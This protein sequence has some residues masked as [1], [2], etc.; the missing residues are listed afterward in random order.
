MTERK[1]NTVT[2]L[3]TAI[4]RQNRVRELSKMSRGV[5]EATRKR[6]CNVIWESRRPS[7]DELI[8]DIL[9]AEGMGR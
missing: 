6:C 5:L 8:A 3:A 7:K 2:D 4:K 9:E 1:S